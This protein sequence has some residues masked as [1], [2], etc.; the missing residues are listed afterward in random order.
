MIDSE[1]LRHFPISFFAMIM[2]LA[3]LAIAW[4][5][6]QQVLQIDPAL[7]SLAG[8]VASLAF[9]ALAALYLTK[10]VK[11]PAAVAE[12]LKHPIKLNFFPTIS[13]SLL[14]LSII[15]L[16]YG[17]GLA[18]LLWMLGSLLHLLMTSYVLNSWLHHEH[19]EVHHI[20]PAWFIPVVGNVL[21][22]ITGVDLGY[23]EISWFFFSIG[24]IFWLVLFTIIFNRVLFHNP[25]PSKLMP[26]FFIL[27]APPA[28]GFIS[29]TKLN[30]DID[31]FAR[32]LY[33]G[34]LFLTLMFFTQAQRFMNLPFALSWWAYSFPMAAI[35]IATLLMF[36]ATGLVL[37]KTLGLILLA[38]LS[39]IVLYL[40][41]RTYV[42]IRGH[43]IC[44]PE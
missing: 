42:A 39:L 16:P 23:Q 10:W 3:G 37:F 36:E 20:N 34:G 1:R 4:R 7:D 31:N 24:I 11:F 38:L 6:A 17:H 13:I 35:T 5:K 29:Y 40:I 30:G 26:T 12:E 14:L 22:P 43:K 44:Q 32:V 41:Y 8:L 15:A 27:I 2:G 19:Y 9:I 21:V 28:L 18:K 25:L 33:Y